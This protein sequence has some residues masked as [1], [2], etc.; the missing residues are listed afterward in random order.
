MRAGPGY[1]QSNPTRT[2]TGAQPQNAPRGV[3]TPLQVLPP[4]PAG[5]AGHHTMCSS[6]VRTT[7]ARRFGG[8]IPLKQYQLIR[9]DGVH[10]ATYAAR[11]FVGVAEHSHLRRDNYFY[12]N[13]CT[14]ARWLNLGNRLFVN[15]NGSPKV[16]L[17][18]GQ[19]LLL[20]LLHRCALTKFTC[21]CFLDMNGNPKRGRVED[22][23]PRQL[24]M[25]QLPH[26]CA[27]GNSCIN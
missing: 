3:H 15:I 16:H 5:A 17:G 10:M 19:L 4:S 26:R 18:T 8:G 24:L 9:R 6:R 12:F 25:I 27:P 20:Q 1:F 11:T 2:H 22:I 13:C 7:P 23:A 21:T 14:G